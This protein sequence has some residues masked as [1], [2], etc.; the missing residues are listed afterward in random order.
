[1]KLFKKSE[2][3][4]SRF[5][6][7]SMMLPKSLI[8]LNPSNTL[9]KNLMLNTLQ[10]TDKETVIYPLISRKVKILI[11]SLILLESLK[12]ALKLSLN[13]FPLVFAGKKVEI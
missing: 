2:Q 3:T 10:K 7:N 5:I 11:T 6:N 12:P 8:K 9:Q 1:L 13:Q 4:Q